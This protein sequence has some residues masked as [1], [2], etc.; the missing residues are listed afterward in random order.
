MKNLEN[1]DDIINPKISAEKIVPKK[2]PKQ[3]ADESLPEINDA[4]LSYIEVKRNAEGFLEAY[5]AAGEPKI[6]NLE[7]K[8]GILT[9]AGER[10]KNTK[11]STK[12]LMVGGFALFLA[13]VAGAKEDKSLNANAAKL[14]RDV[15]YSQQNTPGN[16]YE[17]DGGMT[18]EQYQQMQK[19]QASEDTEFKKQEAEYQAKKAKEDQNRKKAWENINPEEFNDIH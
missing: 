19:K 8:I 13:Q 11:R 4:E 17:T 14:K 9:R 6:E 5:E 15:E 12:M 1:I 16:I 7:N 18:S 2:N 10:I 3:E